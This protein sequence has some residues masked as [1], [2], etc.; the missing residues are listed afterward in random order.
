MVWLLNV[1][2]GAVQSTYMAKLHID[3]RFRIGLCGISAAHCA[4]FP[5]EFGNLH[6]YAFRG[7]IIFGEKPFLGRS[8]FW[9]EAISGEKPFLGRSH[10][11]G[12][13]IFGE[14]PFSRGEAILGRSHLLGRSHFR[15]EAIKKIL[16]PLDPPS[17]P[18]VQ[19]T[20]HTVVYTLK[21]AEI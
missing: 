6:L 2:L 11:R 1:K 21:L 17:K 7:E 10:F 8:P 14:K 9:G 4:H 13:A 19:C 3:R 15:G 20:V 12:E 16:C 18:T 5:P